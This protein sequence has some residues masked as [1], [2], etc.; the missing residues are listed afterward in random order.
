MKKKVGVK[1]PLIPLSKIKNIL[2]VGR[3]RQFSKPYVGSTMLFSRTRP[4]R[5]VLSVSEDS[6]GYLVLRDVSFMSVA[7]IVWKWEEFL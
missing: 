5:K 4:P 7:F 2:K 6:F 1:G 3:F